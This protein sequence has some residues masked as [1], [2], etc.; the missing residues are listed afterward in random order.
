MHLGM[1]MSGLL[2][3]LIFAGTPLLADD[4]FEDFFSQSGWV[5]MQYLSTDKKATL[6]E[7]TNPANVDGFREITPKVV[8]SPRKTYWLRLDFSA[9]DLSEVD[10]WVLRF[11]LLDEVTLYSLGPD[12]IIFRESGKMKRPPDEGPYHAIDFTFRESE[13][14]EG[15]YLYARINHVFRKMILTQP[16]YFHPFIVELDEKYYTRDDLRYY[17]PYLLF[18]GGMLLMFFYSLGIYFMHRDMLF[19]YYSI[20][21]L[22][23]VLYLG[24]RLPLIFGPL[25]QRFPLT[26]VLYNDLIQVVVNI[27]YLIFANFFLKAKTNFP[28]LYKAIRYAI[29]FL[30]LTM[31]LQLAFIL[32]GSLAYAEAYL[33]NF[34]RYFMIV[35]TL[36][37]WVHILLNHKSRIVFFL[38][39]GSFFFLVGGI[40]AMQLN[41]I[42]YMMMGTSIEV[43][44]FS[45]GMGYR[46]KLWEKEKQSIENE[47]NKVRLSALRA[48][49][50]PHFIFNSLNAI[51]AYVISNDTRK[52]SDY[53]NKFSYLI[54][55]ILQYSSKDTIS[56]REEI[57]SLS[58]YV[59]L[60]QLRFRENFNF[61]LITPP[62]F[63][64]EQYRL[65]PLILQPY[66]E[67]AIIHG[68][69]PKKGEKKL[70][71][72]I[73]TGKTNLWISIRDNGIGRSLSRKKKDYQGLQHESMAMSLT[74]KR[75]D[76]SARQKTKENNILVTDL[77][78]EGLP[79][80]TEVC[81]KL[82][83]QKNKI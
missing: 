32:S 5:P 9:I 49:M 10:E 17:T 52:A 66:V 4:T 30:L 72:K 12:G 54:R 15:R 25:E 47:M 70:E 19:I 44:V 11:S 45:L 53:L 20:Y 74:S 73:E 43:F 55:L 48:Q 31:V 8:I 58:L 36:T 56:L 81:I 62:G 39:I 60:E 64:A 65:P 79:A 57:D 27:S 76:L 77:Q 68:V 16:R 69:A 67:N 21:L 24:M 50:N 37:A 51:R 40:A 14:I 3:V 2:L 63:K 33:I 28:L 59:E 80:G 82:P 83:V 34:E 71:I 61:E 78:E 13:L 38:L 7:I 35:F 6:A 1:R 41:D 46:I 22:A 42:K 18:I 23:L 29:V 75:I 26:M